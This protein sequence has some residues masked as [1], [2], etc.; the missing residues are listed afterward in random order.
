MSIVLYKISLAWLQKRERAGGR[1]GECKRRNIR[2]DKNVTKHHP[3]CWQQFLI[4][5]L[6]DTSFFL[7]LS[8]LWV[9]SCK[10]LTYSPN[11]NLTTAR[12]RHIADTDNTTTEPGM[13]R[14]R[15]KKSYL[16]HLKQN[17]CWR[18]VWARRKGQVVLSPACALHFI[19]WFLSAMC[20]CEHTNDTYWPLYMS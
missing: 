14:K 10:T 16:S 12:E 4:I 18:I 6:S 7:H 1:V 8:F 19:W 20:Y 11:E 3:D 5:L 15:M 13:T 9:K 2:S 17:V